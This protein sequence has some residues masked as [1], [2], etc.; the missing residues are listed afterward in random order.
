MSRSWIRLDHG[1]L[2]DT[3]WAQMDDSTA[4]A[5]ITAYLLQCRRDDRPFSSESELIRLLRKEG[6]DEPELRVARMG[7]ML[8]RAPLD[9]PDGEVGIR[10][11]D[12]YQPSRR[13]PSDDPEYRR[14]FRAGR[15]QSTGL[16]QTPPDSTTADTVRYGTDIT[17]I[18]DDAP[19]GASGSIE[20]LGDVMG[21]VAP[22]WRPPKK[23]AAKG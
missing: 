20:P 9:G 6:I 16:H 15:R 18:T 19:A 8:E 7:H 3:G 4:R 12:Q 21:R 17:D 2:D 1:L 5:W 10:N 14:G 13:G 22:G 23:P 11:Y